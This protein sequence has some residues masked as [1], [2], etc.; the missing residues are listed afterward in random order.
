M[1]ASRI[2]IALCAAIFL[3]ALAGSI[4]LL[5]PAQAATVEIVQDGKTLYTFDLSGHVEKER[6]EIRCAEGNN[7]IYIGPE[8]ICVESADCADQTCVNMGYLQSSALPIVCLPH[9]LVIRYAD[10]AAQSDGAAQ[11]DGVSE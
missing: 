1:K 11:V 7:V 5:H 10:G 8:G 6:I 3:L 4:H 9:K 2:C